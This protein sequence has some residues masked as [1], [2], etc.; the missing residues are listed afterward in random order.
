MINQVSHDMLDEISSPSDGPKSVS[1][2]PKSVLQ[3]HIYPSS[4][5]TGVLFPGGMCQTV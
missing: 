1:V 3:E 2:V 4:L 5:G